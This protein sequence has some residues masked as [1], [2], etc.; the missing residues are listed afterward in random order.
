VLNTASGLK[1]DTVYFSEDEIGGTCNTHGKVIN[2]HK[3]VCENLHLKNIT[4]KICECMELTKRTKFM[5]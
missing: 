3:I 1:L 2:A 5:A 4:E